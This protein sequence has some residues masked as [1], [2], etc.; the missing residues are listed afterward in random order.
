MNKTIE[1]RKIWVEGTTIKYE[2]YD[3]T[4]MQLLQTDRVEAFINFYNTE[5]FNFVPENL[6]QSVLAIP[7]TLYLLPITYF[8]NVELI[9][10]CMDKTL[11]ENLSEIYNAYSKIYGPFKDE[12]RGKVSPV[13][14]E[15]NN[16][17]QSKYKNVVFFSGGVD[18]CSAGINN[19]GEK[20]VL[21]SVPSIEALA[22]NEGDLRNEKFNLIKEFSQITNSKWILISN[23]FNECIFNDNKIQKNLSEKLS[24]A[25]F[26]FDGWFGVKYL[27]NMCSVAPF[28]YAIGIRE[29]IMGSTFEQEEENCY[30]NYDGANPVLSDSMKFV[31]MYF[32]EQDE[33]YTRRSQKVKNIVSWCKKW[34]KKVKL[35]TCFDDKS[36]QC[37]LCPKCIRTQLNILCAG[38]NPK[39][40]GFER[41]SE[42]QFSRLLRS[43][44]YYEKNACWHWD[45]FDSIDD[46]M[47]YPYCNKMLHWLKAIGYKEY[48]KKAGK[49]KKIRSINRIFKFYRYPRYIKKIYMNIRKKLQ[50]YK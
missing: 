24:S 6:S 11:Y 39:D 38:E 34:G 3:N 16:A 17:L 29:F 20:T 18:A 22:K 15:Q 1:L 45:I 36:Y 21:V 50:N 35:W 33:L 42:K 46:T 9:L 12:W 14:I 41:F 23:N 31:N 10:P 13:K 7:I 5:E 28:A 40:W 43:F 44:R 48:L 19:P 27:G 49:A 30:I 4:G 2:I 26:R 25:A 8:Y 47:V 37:G 32:A